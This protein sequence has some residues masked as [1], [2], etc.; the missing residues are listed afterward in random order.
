MSAGASTNTAYGD[1]IDLLYL[2]DFHNFSDLQPWYSF[3]STLL[4]ASESLILIDSNIDY[5][6]GHVHALQRESKLDD[7]IY[8]DHLF[9]KDIDDYCNRVPKLAPWINLSRAKRQ[10]R[11][12]LETDWKRDLLCLR[13]DAKNALFSSKVIELCKSKYK[14]PVSDISELTKGRAYKVG[15][16]LDRSKSLFGGDNTIW[17]C[18]LKVA[19]P[20][21][22]EPEF[23]ILNQKLIVPNTS[24]LI[25]KAIL[26]DHERYKLDNVVL[27][28]YEVTDLAPWLT[29]Q[30]IPY[31]LVSAHDTNQNASFPEF[32][33]IAQEGRFHFPESLK[34]LSSEM[35][36][37]S[38]TQ[39]AGGKYSFGHSS[40]RFKDDRVYSCNWSIFSLRQ[41]VMNLYVLGSFYCKNKSK[42]RHMCFLMGGQLELLCKE[43]CIAYA[44]VD[45]MFREYK[46]YQFDSELT[47]PEFYTEKVKHI[48][49]RISQAA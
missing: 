15:G 37:F 27:E 38:Y 36:T 6:D 7:S 21:H 9:F 18:I 10:Q 16:G 17:T 45:A 13:S 40:Q 48:G 25:K 39:R 22:G 11:T 47:L 5:T 28:N 41:A 2:S 49:C 24:R 3:Q 29:D 43:S 32:F 46:R 20:E 8:C 26:K 19:S 23:F 14:I 33:R 31:E 42:R 1:R 12:S 4:D 30:K 34:E 35:Q 44:E